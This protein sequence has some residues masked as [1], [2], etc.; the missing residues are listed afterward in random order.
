MLRCFTR[1]TCLFCI[2]AAHSHCSSF[3]GSTTKLTR[4]WTCWRF[5]VSSPFILKL[6]FSPW[7]VHQ[8]TCSPLCW[9]L[10]HHASSWLVDLVRTDLLPAPPPCKSVGC[11]SPFPTELSSLTSTSKHTFFIL[12]WGHLSILYHI[13]P[14]SLIPPY[15]CIYFHCFPP[16]GGSLCFSHFLLMSIKFAFQRERSILSL[17]SVPISHLFFPN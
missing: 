12:L 4:R 14:T 5:V 15:Y 13:T 1:L 17:R 9:L 3:C 10:E 8:S 16:V 6:F 2:T 11:I 7:N